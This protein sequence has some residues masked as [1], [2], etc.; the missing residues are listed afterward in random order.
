MVRLQYDR[1]ICH[2]FRGKKSALNRV[3]ALRV[4]SLACCRRQL[5]KMA[6]GFMAVRCIWFITQFRTSRAKIDCLLWFIRNSINSSTLHS[7]TKALF[8]S[9][10]FHSLKY[11]TFSDIFLHG[12]VVIYWSL[13]QSNHKFIDHTRFFCDV[14]RFC[15]FYSTLWR[16]SG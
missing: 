12:L 6:S 2:C 7:I 5:I 16:V 15:F 3:Y 10:H 8:V 1:I 4:K 14:L 13:H 9:N 11:S